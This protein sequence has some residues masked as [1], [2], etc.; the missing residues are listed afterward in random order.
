M[1][2]RYTDKERKKY[3]KSALRMMNRKRNPLSLCAS[4]KELGVSYV[5]L[6][7]WIEK[8]NNDEI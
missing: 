3:V 8:Y 4:A 2:I 7:S 6:R 5:T 1:S